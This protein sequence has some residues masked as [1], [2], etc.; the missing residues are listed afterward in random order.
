MYDRYFPYG[1]SHPKFENR[2]NAAVQVKLDE[3]IRV[4]GGEELFF[5]GIEH[6]TED[7]ITNVFEEA[8]KMQ[9]VFHKIDQKAK[10]AAEA[11][12]G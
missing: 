4:T 6:L 3:L 12:S 2:D 8:Q 7:E 1:V 9:R 10:A 5:S 11:V